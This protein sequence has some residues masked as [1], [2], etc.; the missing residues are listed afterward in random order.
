MGSRCSSIKATTAI[1][2]AGATLALVAAFV[3]LTDDPGSS[4]VPAAILWIGTALALGSASCG[5]CCLSRLFKRRAPTPERAATDDAA[6]GGSVP[7][8]DNPYARS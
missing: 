7:D 3:A 6:P 8:A 5:G 2:V 4:A 1:G